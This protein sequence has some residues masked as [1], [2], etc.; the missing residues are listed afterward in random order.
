MM[1]DE[2][3]AGLSR[4]PR[5]LP[6]KYL[7][8]ARGSEL[9]EAICETPEYYL[10]RADLALLEHHLPEMAALVGTDAHVIEFGSGAGVKTRR[11]L[12]ALESPRAYTP[13]EISA[14][15]LDASA[16]ELRAA[17]PDIEIRP[18]QADY[19]QPIA[20]E[21]L[22]IDPPARRRIVFFPGSTISNFSHEEARHF[23]TRMRRIVEPDGAVLIG[24]DLDKEPKR[25]LA[26]YDDSQGVTAGFN[27]NLLERINRELGADFDIGSFRHQARYDDELHRIEM[28][29]VADRAMTV[30]L[31]GNRFQFA[32]GESIH[33]ENSHKYSVADFQALAASAGLESKQVWKDPEGLFSTHYLEP[34]V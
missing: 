10:T 22:T 23:L 6:Y 33:T 17:F 5:T 13:I 11:L 29:L 32:E 26:A 31:A 16:G 9:F 21:N 30:T 14:S 3:L 8:D 18:L 25:L 20:D 27:L 24:V 15:A 28:H 12:A 19:L 7:Y 34:S 1:L 4:R 2:V